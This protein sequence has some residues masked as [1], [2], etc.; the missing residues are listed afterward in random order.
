MTTLAHT[1]L[2]QDLPR[3]VGWDVFGHFPDLEGVSAAEEHLGG[4]RM[5]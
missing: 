1:F 4:I 2:T 5:I 3:K